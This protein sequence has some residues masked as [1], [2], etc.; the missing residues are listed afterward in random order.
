MKNSWIK[1]RCA[2][3]IATALVAVG[4]VM[5]SSLA[6][7]AFPERPL[8]IVVPFTPGGGTDIVARQLAKGLTDVLG[9]SVIVENRPGGS[10]IIGTENVAKSPADGYSLLMATFAHAVNPAIHRKLPYD[11]DKAFAPVALIGKS[12]NVLVVSTKSKFNSV[13]DI[14][15]YA[16]AHPGRLTFGSYGNGTSAHLAGEMFKSLGHVD[17]LHVPYKGAGPGINDLMG[18]QIDMIFSTSASVSGQ[19]KNGQLRALAVTTKERSPSY[20]GVPTVAESG[21]PG[22]FVD[23]WYGVF[24]PQ[25]TP[26]DVID[27]LNSAIKKVS[28]NAEFQTALKLEGLVADVGTPEA[29]GDYVKEEEARW[30]KIVQQAGITDKP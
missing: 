20:P 19:I 26:K 2:K 14:L 30:T 28:A 3:S 4:T 11:T 13:Q 16:R 23:S 29:L 12:P 27:K 21:V 24:V 8:R 7:A 18:G 15:A 10:T 5:A 17:I 9:Q 22:Y 1:A 25:G 6:Q